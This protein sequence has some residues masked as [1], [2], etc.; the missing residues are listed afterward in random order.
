MTTKKNINR[1]SR[2][3]DALEEMLRQHP[4][5]SQFRQINWKHL[6]AHSGL[7]EILPAA[8]I[9]REGHPA[10]YGWLIVK[11]EVKLVR[12][13]TKGQVLLVD[14]LLPGELFGV[15]FYRD[16][17]VQPATAVA[18]KATRLLAF[19]L[20]ILLD[21]LD[22]NPTLQTALLQD[23]C[24][25]L[26]QSVAMRGLALEELPVRMATILCRLHEKFG[27]IIPETR[28]TL[29]ELAGTTT[30][31]AIRATREL[32]EQGVLRLGRGVIEV[33]SLHQLHARSALA[34]SHVHSGVMT[35]GQK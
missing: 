7:R 30:E 12:H 10:Q 24:L 28:A 34:A 21:E 14:I 9:C 8:A 32:E 19:P 27:R 4:V 23:T 1:K 17:P 3:P 31:S 33:V 22:G 11:G 25:K 13:T 15:V 6:V 5:L 29:A 18:V 16:Q 20:S 35:P 26:C 2:I